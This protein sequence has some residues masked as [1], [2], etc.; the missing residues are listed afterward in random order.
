VIGA[1]Q[2]GRTCAPRIPIAVL[3]NDIEWLGR[4]VPEVT[5]EETERGSR[6]IVTYARAK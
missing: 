5:W 3:R 1:D 2:I 4:I 6:A